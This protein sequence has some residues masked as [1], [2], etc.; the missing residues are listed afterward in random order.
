MAE[1]LSLL[2]IAQWRRVGLVRR[3][4]IYGRR[5]ALWEFEQAQKLLELIGGSRRCPKL[6]LYLMIPWTAWI[7][8]FGPMTG[9]PPH[10]AQTHGPLNQV[11]GSPTI[12]PQLRTGQSFKPTR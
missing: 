7:R 12:T 8:Q 6:V 2:W 3:L 11:V 9:S 4:E 5:I 1:L 10:V